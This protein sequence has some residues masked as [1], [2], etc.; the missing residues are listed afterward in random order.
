MSLMRGALVT[1][2]HQLLAFLMCRLGVA[3]R[4][5]AESYR[6]EALKHDL[7]QN[8]QNL[9]WLGKFFGAN[10]V[11]PTNIAGLVIVVSLVGYLVTLFF[12]GPEIAD[13]RQTLAGIILTVLGYILGSF[14]KKGA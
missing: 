4:Q 11:A 14:T 8:L 3:A 9:G 10:A 2:L 7:E 13:A 6:V 12:S 1:P 5:E